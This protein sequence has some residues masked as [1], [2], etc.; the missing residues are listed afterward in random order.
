M[1]SRL[2]GRRRPGLRGELTEEERVTALNQLHPIP[3]DSIWI[4]H[5]FYIDLSPPDLTPEDFY[6]PTHTKIQITISIVPT[7]RASFGNTLHLT[8]NAP[9]LSGV[10]P[11]FQSRTFRQPSER[12][13]ARVII[14]EVSTFLTEGGKTSNGLMIM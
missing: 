10:L 7:S 5:K 3:T 9:F 2:F 8:Q 13:N 6:N 11:H 12:K 14:E 1:A 4:P